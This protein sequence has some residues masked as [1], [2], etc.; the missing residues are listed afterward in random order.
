M[1]EV[2]FTEQ[3]IFTLVA[4]FSTNKPCIELIMHIT[5]CV[6][7]R[8]REDVYDMTFPMRIFD[9]YSDP[10]EEWGTLSQEAQ[11]HVAEIKAHP[12][13]IEADYIR[14]C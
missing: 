1:S 12:R 7:G 6:T 3:E 2:K 5:Q 10:I 9:L 4:E 8:A 14:I 13:Y 11:D